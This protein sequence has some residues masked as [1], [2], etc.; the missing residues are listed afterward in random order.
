VKRRI[1]GADLMQAENL[2]RLRLCYGTALILSD[3]QRA[4]RTCGISK[5][6]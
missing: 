3:A 6:A 2:D 4:L 1:A 5:K